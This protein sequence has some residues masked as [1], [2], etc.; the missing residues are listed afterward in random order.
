MSG[1]PVG[2]LRAVKANHGMPGHPLPSPGGFGKWW[3]VFGIAAI[4]TALTCLPGSIG[5]LG[6]DRAGLAQGEAW[7]LL[8]AHFVHVDSAHLFYNLF[9]MCLICELLWNRLA[10]RH[11]AGILLASAFCV[12]A[13]L[14]WLQ[15]HVVWYVGLSGALHG[16]WAATALGGC[17]PEKVPASTVAATGSD[18][19]MHAGAAAY[20]RICCAALAL[21]VVKLGHEWAGGYALAIDANGSPVVAA[22]HLYGAVAGCAYIVAWHSLRNRFALPAKHRAAAREAGFV[23]K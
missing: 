16:L 22:A 7:R 9:G 17:R 2:C 10:F 6:Y 15:P 4:S 12:I 8:T 5:A 13:A 14:W 19:P 18:A 1:R 23:L 11:A 3:F 20:R 21:L